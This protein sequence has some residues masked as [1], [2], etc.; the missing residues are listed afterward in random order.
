M[1]QNAFPF[2]K[3]DP[4]QLLSYCLAH[5]S[6]SIQARVVSQKKRVVF[7]QKKRLKPSCFFLQKNT[8]FVFVLNLKKNKKLKK[9]KKHVFFLFFVFCYTRVFNRYI[10]IKYCYCEHLGLSKMLKH[11]FMGRVFRSHTF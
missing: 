5:V 11:T 2:N 4:N 6:T 9:T 3:R 1:S 10:L 7:L 8:F